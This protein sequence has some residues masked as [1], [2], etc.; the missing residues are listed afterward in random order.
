MTST[1]TQVRG[2]DFAI[3]NRFVNL[4]YLASGAYG[5]VMYVCDD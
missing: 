4:K 1:N 3:G 2:Q 5:M